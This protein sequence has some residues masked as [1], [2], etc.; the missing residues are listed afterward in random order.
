MANSRNICK[1]TC[2]TVGA[3]AMTLGA[4]VTGFV[5]FPAALDGKTITYLVVDANG[6][7]RE[8]GRGVY[9]H[10]TKALT[11]A[12]ILASTNSDSAISLS[13]SSQVSIAASYEEM[14]WFDDAQTFTAAQQS[15][16]QTNLGV[17]ASEPS[18]R[19][20]LTSATPVL[21]ETVSGASTIYLTPYKGNMAPVW[22]G[23]SWYWLPF[24]EL[25]QA[26]SDA[27]KSPAAAGA[28]SAYDMLQWRDGTTWRCT[29]G[30]AWS[31]VTTRGTGAGT[32]ELVWQN[33]YLVNKYDISNGPAAGYGLY[34]GSICTNASSTVDFTFGGL[35][36]GGV[37]GVLN[38]WN[39]YNRARVATRVADS[40]DSW[41]YGTASFRAANNSTTMRVTFFVGLID[42]IIAAKYSAVGGGAGG[43]GS[44]AG[45]GLNS[46]TAFSGVPGL[47]SVT[48]MATSFVGNYEGFPTLGQN[49]V[50]ALESRDTATTATFYG[51]AGVPTFVQNGLFFESRL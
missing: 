43:G 11:R 20:T 38:I 9:T 7:G 22:N 51:D 37:A 31:N 45:V 41:T 36:A 14:L 48:G 25:S 28:S 13:G 27:T 5:A 44:E 21:T 35:G 6:T 34:R 10:S 8:L 12:T 18:G 19:L 30:P 15:N 1:M 16:I 33:G 2:A 42:D 32:T 17:G 47:L 46:T 4:A 3:G 23:S 39:N 26:L 29:R 50:Q 49:Y 24:A 40:T